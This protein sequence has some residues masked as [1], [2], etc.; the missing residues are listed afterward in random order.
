[1]SEKIPPCDDGACEC[2]TCGMPLSDAEDG[3][4]EG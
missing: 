1:M 2:F 3:E 4:G